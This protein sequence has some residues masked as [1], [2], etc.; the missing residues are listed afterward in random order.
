MIYSDSGRSSDL[1]LP[2]SAFPHLPVQ[3]HSVRIHRELQQ[4]VLSPI[5][6]AFPH[7]LNLFLAPK[8]GTKIEDNPILRLAFNI[9]FRETFLSCWYRK[10]SIFGELFSDFNLWS[11]CFLPVSFLEIR[12]EPIRFPLTSTAKVGN[13]FLKFYTKVEKESIIN[14]LFLCIA[15]NVAE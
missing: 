5:C 15:T 2:R 9:K 1:S 11:V 13:Y 7:W 8:T 12:H 14:T 3:W 6:T 4:R 10:F